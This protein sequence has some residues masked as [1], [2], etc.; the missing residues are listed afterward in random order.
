ML[1]RG[2]HWLV[3]PLL[4]RR[5]KKVYNIDNWLAESEK[6]INN[7]DDKPKAF[8]EVKNETLDVTN[9]GNTK[10]PK[11]PF[12]WGHLVVKVN[13]YQLFIF[14]SVGICGSLLWS[15]SCIGVS[16]KVVVE[17]VVTYSHSA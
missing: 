2:K 14:S 9:C 13:F 8:E 4:Q 5:I 1:A 17:R 6:R 11:I 16:K 10:S 3:E 12:T 15:F 7:R